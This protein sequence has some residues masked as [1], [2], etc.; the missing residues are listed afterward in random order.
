LPETSEKIE[1]GRKFGGDPPNNSAK[2]IRGLAAKK[3]RL[4]RSRFFQ[5]AGKPPN[6]R[7]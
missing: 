4:R 1:F 7:Q 6:I 2:Q 3:W 5:G